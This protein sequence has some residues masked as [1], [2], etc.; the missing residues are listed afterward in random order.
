MRLDAK[1][2]EARDEK[3][4]ELYQLGVTPINIK[5]RFG[6]VDIHKILR[7]HGIEPNQKPWFSKQ[8]LRRGSE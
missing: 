4:I 8:A 7:K 1:R 3:I 2:R 5:L 6:S